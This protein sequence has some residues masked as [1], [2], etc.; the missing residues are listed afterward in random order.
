MVVDEVDLAL[1]VLQLELFAKIAWMMHR[2]VDKIEDAE[3]VPDSTFEN[4]AL[5]RQWTFC[6]MIPQSP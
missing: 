5:N 1:L 2:K 6:L 3:L 4:V